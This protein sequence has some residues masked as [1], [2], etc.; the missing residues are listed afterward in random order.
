M[1]ND[2]ALRIHSSFLRCVSASGK[3]TAHLPEP[4]ADP[5]DALVFDLDGVLYDHSIWRRWLLQLLG[6]L[7]LHTNYTS[8]FR[9]WDCD[10]AQQVAWGNLTYWTAMR[11]FLLA[12]GLSA[13]QVDEVEAAGRS[14]F[15]A[16]EQMIRPFPNVRSS[17]RQLSLR[18]LK[19]NLVTAFPWTCEQLADRLDRL[20]MANLFSHTSSARDWPQATP[21]RQRLADSLETAGLAPAR[22][23]YVGRLKCEL[24]AAAQL[25]MPTIAFNQEPDATADFQ[26]EQ[27]DTLPQM[28]PTDAVRL[29]AAG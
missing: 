21:A 19:L 4:L 7:G 5:V 6:K 14:R 18:G 12:A 2:P 20:E 16:A 22:T 9:V 10:Y 28:I 15:S 17:L 8:F 27:F 24:Q 11:S 3:T 13:G 26:L 1:S 25:G 29:L 23:A